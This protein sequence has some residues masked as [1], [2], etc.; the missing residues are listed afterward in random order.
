[1]KSFGRFWNYGGMSLKT[2]KRKTK[3]NG[4]SEYKSSHC[5]SVRNSQSCGFCV[6][7]SL[8]WA[9]CSP[10]KYIP[11]QSVWPQTPQ[12]WSPIISCPCL[13]LQITLGGDKSWPYWMKRNQGWVCIPGCYFGLLTKAYQHVLFLNEQLLTTLSSSSLSNVQRLIA[14]DAK[15]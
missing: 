2:L 6:F 13:V 11:L 14:L 7:N 3:H 4:I 9:A 1:M 10:S 8:T 15:W 12:S 5:C